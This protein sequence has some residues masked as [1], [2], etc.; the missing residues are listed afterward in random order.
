M[1]PNAVVDAVKAH[2]N[3]LVHLVRS[4]FAAAI[5]SALLPAVLAAQQP[6]SSLAGRIDRVL[7]PLATSSGPGCAVGVNQNGRT[8]ERAYG[9]AELEFGTANTPQTIFESGSLAKQFTA[10]A[11]VLLALDGKLKLDE[12]VRKYVPELPD[13]GAPLTIRHLLTHTS[14]LRDWGS[15]IALT[16]F[17]RGDRMVTEQFALDVITRQKGIDFTPG[18]EY[19]YSNSGYNTLA[20]IVERVSKQAFFVFTDERLFKPLGM[21]NSQWRVDYTR[22]IKGRAQAYAPGLAGSF[23]LD[24]PFMNVYGN[25]GLLTTVGD[26]LKWNTMLETRSLGAALVD[27]M[28]RRMVLNSGTTIPYALGIVDAPYRGQRQIAHSGS[29]A[30]YSTYLTRFP[31][32]KLSIAVLCNGANTGPT[33]LTYRLV[34]AIAG[35]FAAAAPPDTVALSPADGQRRAGLYRDEATHQQLSITYENGAL[36][37][38]GGA[39]LRPLRDGGYLAAAGPIKWHFDLGADGRVTRVRRVTADGESRFAPEKPWTPTA[40]ELAALAGVW[41]S[42]EADAS[43]T[44]AVDAGQL[45]VSRRPG[46]R[47]A[48]RPLYKDHFT[49]PELQ[50]VLWS[51]RDAAGR[52]TM[53]VG[54]SRMRDMPFTRVGK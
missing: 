5:M 43:F 27:S 46:L 4:V 18:A 30:G 34:D 36:R 50:A 3:N 41:H 39:I 16:G 12:P 49:S 9:M 35:P 51:T 33:A 1:K 8:V 17:G 26:L 15:V 54:A 6:D 42:D 10:A 20:L 22:L 40:A 24:M 14:G 45:I 48:L 23:K 11:V 31:Q 52:V 21:T 2:D 53:H 32:Q 7:A 29:T 44:L 19:S 25:G 13:Y 37:V 28:E 38:A 47:A